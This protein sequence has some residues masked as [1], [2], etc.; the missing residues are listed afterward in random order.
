MIY[1]SDAPNIRSIVIKRRNS[2]LAHDVYF[3]Q[4][5]NHIYSG[6]AFAWVLYKVSVLL[7]AY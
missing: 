2:Y 1:F 7:P 3:V 6:C 5:P 4:K